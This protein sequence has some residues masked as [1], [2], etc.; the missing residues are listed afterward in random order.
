MTTLTRPGL[1]SPSVSN[2]VGG[3]GRP[4]L[5]LTLDVPFDPRAV[6]FAVDSA[7]ELGEPLI[8]AN[9]VEVPPLPLSVIMGYDQLEYTPA[10]AEAMMAPPELARSLGVAVE[11]LK[12]KSLHPIQ[13]VLQVVS[14]RDPGLLVFGP[15]RR[16]LPRVRYRRATR[17][18]R[19][20]APCLVWLAE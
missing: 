11:R 1:E 20:R 14:E 15:D 8:V 7:V 4:V 19:E 2:A 3:R 6:V 16:K 18:I 12:I 5:L 17:A 10:M 9:F 13:A